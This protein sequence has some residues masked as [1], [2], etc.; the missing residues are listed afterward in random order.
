[1]AAASGCRGRVAG[2]GRAWPKVD[3]SP[4][5]RVGNRRFLPPARPATR[6]S[7]AA[8]PPCNVCTRHSTRW[9]GEHAL[10]VAPRPR[11]RWAPRAPTCLVTTRPPFIAPGEVSFGQ[12]PS[13]TR[14]AKSR[15]FWWPPAPARGRHPATVAAGTAVGG[16]HSRKRVMREKRETKSDDDARCQNSSS[17]SL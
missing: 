15:Q 3:R 5:P 17:S 16:P 10:P 4:L 14:V 11:I 9:A 6:S 1:M 2:R 8:L 13:S 12:P 7:G